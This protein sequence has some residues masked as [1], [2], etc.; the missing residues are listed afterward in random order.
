MP[1]RRPPTSP[2]G[3]PGRPIYS[4]TE[5]QRE[6]HR[7]SHRP[8]RSYIAPQTQAPPEFAC[9]KPRRR[10]RARPLRCVPPPRGTAP[11]WTPSH[12]RQLHPRRSAAK[13]HRN[14]PH[15]KVT[16]RSHRAGIAAYRAPGRAAARLRNA[17]IGAAERAAGARS[18]P[19]AL[20]PSR[21]F[22]DLALNERSIHRAPVQCAS[23]W[24]NSHPSW[25][26]TR[27]F[28]KMLRLAL[29]SDLNDDTIVLNM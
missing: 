19:E 27:H 28:A 10:I 22:R 7:R 12:R 17:S 20:C 4:V 13:R 11:T 16:Q 9:G 26:R 14:T 8:G 29:Q 18:P 2:R 5:R 6:G 15:R 25:Q 24:R 21:P 1:D 3:V 23:A